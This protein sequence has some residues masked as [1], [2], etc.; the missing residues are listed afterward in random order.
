MPHTAAEAPKEKNPLLSFQQ[1]L[2]KTE[3]RRFWK[4]FQILGEAGANGI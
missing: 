1:G 4:W 2:D 3:N